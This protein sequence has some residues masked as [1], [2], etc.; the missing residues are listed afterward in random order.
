MYFGCSVTQFWSDSMGIFSFCK[1]SQKQYLDYT[2]KQKQE[3]KKSTHL[4]IYLAY[5]FI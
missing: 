3:N 1:I 5:F 4:L 2:H